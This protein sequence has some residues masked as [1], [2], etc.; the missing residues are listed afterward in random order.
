[1]PESVFLLLVRMKRLSNMGIKYSITAFKKK[2]S[3]IAE[4]PSYIYTVAPASSCSYAPETTT[5]SVTLTFDLMTLNFIGV[6][7]WTWLFIL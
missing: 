1:M 4:E 3:C 2:S 5:F 7:Y 6:L